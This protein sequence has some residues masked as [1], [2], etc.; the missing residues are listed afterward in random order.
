MMVIDYA[1]GLALIAVVGGALVAG[2]I[3]MVKRVGRGAIVIGVLGALLLGGV[4]G[5]VIL[6]AIL[7]VALAR[8]WLRRK[9]A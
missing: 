3:L 6:K 8:L 5:A 9:P 2:G 4:A 7:G 1:A